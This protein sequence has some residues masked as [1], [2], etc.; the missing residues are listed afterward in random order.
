VEWYKFAHE[1]FAT[2]LEVDSSPIGGPGTIAEID[3]SKFGK[4][5]YHCGRRVEVFGGIERGTRKCFLISVEDR[6]AATLIPI[7]KQYILTGTL[8]MP[9]C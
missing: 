8:I 6:S 3:K 7:I 4:R 2:I 1:V 9:D 5:K